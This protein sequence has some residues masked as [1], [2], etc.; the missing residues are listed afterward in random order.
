MRFIL[1]A[2]GSV[3]ELETQLLISQNLGYVDRDT[4]HPLIEDANE[5]GRMLS[6]LFSK[7]E[8]KTIQ[9]SSH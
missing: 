5:I 1:I 8:A 7:L 6:G 2:R 3:A 9:Q 4:A